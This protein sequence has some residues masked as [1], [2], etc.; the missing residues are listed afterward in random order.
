LEFTVFHVEA[1]AVSAEDGLGIH[2]DRSGLRHPRISDLTIIPRYKEAT[3][4][5]RL[6]RQPMNVAL[7][8]TRPV[9]VNRDEPILVVRVRVG[10]FHPDEAPP[11]G[12]SRNVEGPGALK[13]TPPN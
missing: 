6:R 3:D 9:T 2:T 7:L 12:T 10:A 8:K 11:L 13:L 4:H 1:A 5:E